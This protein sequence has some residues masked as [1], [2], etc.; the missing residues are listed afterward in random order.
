MQIRLPSVFVNAE[1]EP[2]APSIEWYVERLLEDAD[3][4]AIVLDS[5]GGQAEVGGCPGWNV[6]RLASHLGDVHRWAAYCAANSKPPESRDEFRMPAEAEPGVWLRAGASALAEVLLKV[7]PDAPTWH[8]F[9]VERVARVWPRR[10]AQETSMHRWDAQSAMGTA[11]AIDPALASDGIDEYFTI[12]AARVMKRQEITSLPGSLHVHCTDIAGEWLAWTDDHG[13]H[14]ER[15]H[16]KADA[17]LR[18]PAEALLLRLWGRTSPRAD[19]LQP[20]GDESVL[21]AW[22]AIGGQ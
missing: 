22:L 6:K 5:G 8:P 20:I 17:A 18:G 16:Q 13:F 15:A 3:N 11:A 2:S 21:N 10:Q 1:P 7:D 4:F 14:L 9:P 19:E 12:F